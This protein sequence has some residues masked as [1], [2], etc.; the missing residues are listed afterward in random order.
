MKTAEKHDWPAQNIY[1]TSQTTWKDGVPV[2]ILSIIVISPQENVDLSENGGYSFLAASPSELG[3]LRI[4]CC[5]TCRRKIVLSSEFPPSLSTPRAARN[6]SSGAVRPVACCQGC[7]G[8]WVC[9][10]MLCTPLYPM[11]LLI[12]IPIKWLFHWEYTLFP[13]KPTW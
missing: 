3:T 10:K 8:T 2:F 5:F 11:V 4:V 13:D 9:L 6:A 12:I 7:V 1:K